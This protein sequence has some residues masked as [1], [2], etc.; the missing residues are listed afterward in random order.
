VNSNTFGNYDINKILIPLSGTFGVSNS[1]HITT[2]ILGNDGG[3][4]SGPL[5]NSDG[6]KTIQKIR[7]ILEK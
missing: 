6:Y 5:R 4:I 7:L 1:S 3:Y 2:L